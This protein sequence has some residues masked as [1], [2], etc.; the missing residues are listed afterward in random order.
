L[1]QV[2]YNPFQHLAFA[3]QFLRTFAVFPDGGVFSEA[4]DFG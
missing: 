2:E 3:S 4:D 1:V